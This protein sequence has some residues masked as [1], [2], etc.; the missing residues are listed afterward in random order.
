MAIKAVLFDLGGTLVKYD[1]AH[2]GEVFQRILLS[3]GVSRSLDETKSA[4]LNAEEEAKDTGLLASF[5]KMKCEQYWHQ[6][7]ALV[8]KHLGIAE[9]VEVARI[10][11]SKWFDFVNFTLYPEVENVLLEL[12]QRGLKLGLISTAYEE[13]IHFI[14]A[15]VNLEKASFDVIVGVDTI[16]KVKPDRGIFTYAISKLNVRSE[17]AM[18]VGDHVEADYRG[19]ENAGLHAL[20]VDRTETPQSGLKTIRTL[21]EILPQIN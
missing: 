20:L 18:F 21:K 9:N 13:E 12:Q 6:W 17:E 4:F 19:A 14:L 3:L 2:A 16:Q 1:V 10:V 5:G 8:L 7:D 15:E 11:Q